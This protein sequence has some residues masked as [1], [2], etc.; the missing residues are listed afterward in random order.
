MSFK[1]QNTVEVTAKREHRQWSSLWIVYGVS[2][3]EKGTLTMISTY[4]TSQLVAWRLGA[5]QKSTDTLASFTIAVVEGLC[6]IDEMAVEIC[7]MASGK[8]TELDFFLHPPALWNIEEVGGLSKLEWLSPTI[9]SLHIRNWKLVNWS[10]CFS[11]TMCP[12][13]R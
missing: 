1:R 7:E 11:F 4:L 3:V 5:H 8:V 2:P 10:L 9:I 13:Y 6:A 12:N